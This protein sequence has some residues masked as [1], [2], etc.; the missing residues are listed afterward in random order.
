[1]GAISLLA[2]IPAVADPQ[3]LVKIMFGHRYASI[4]SGV[5]PMV[6]AGAGL[7]MLYLLVTFSVVIDDRRWALLLVLGVTMQATGIG[8]FHATVM[9]L[10]LINELGFHALIPRRRHV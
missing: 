4:A 2:I 8:L 9:V 3:L 10:L 6:V 7:A 5:L 1:V